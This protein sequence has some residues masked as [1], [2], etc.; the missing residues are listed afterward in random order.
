MQLVQ[1]L[2]FAVHIETQVG[3]I[4]GQ[5]DVP[6]VTG[7]RRPIPFDVAIILSRQE[8][9]IIC[10]P[11]HSIKY[12]LRPATPDHKLITVARIRFNDIGAIE[13]RWLVLS[14][15]A[16]GQVVELSRLILISCFILICTF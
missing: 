12:N 9:S 16:G 8:H 7:A 6:P 11:G 13:H 3:L 15:L 10:L 1:L 14:N 2:S 4:V 5:K